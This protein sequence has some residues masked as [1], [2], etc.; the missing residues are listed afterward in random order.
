M[1]NLNKTLLM[2]HLTRDPEQRHL[3]TGTSV[4]SFSIATSRRFRGRDEQSKEETTFVDCEAW[5][6]TGELIHEHL[7]KGDPL[8]VEGRLKFDSWTDKQG[9]KR[10]KLSVVA[11]RMEFLGGKQERQGFGERV[12]GDQPPGLGP[13]PTSEVPF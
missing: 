12:S 1:P 11:E 2:G 13:Q 10:S 9:N 4:T 7:R 3:P 5:G 8:F 6:K